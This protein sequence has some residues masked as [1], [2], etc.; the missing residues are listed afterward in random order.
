[1]IGKVYCL[2]LATIVFPSV[3]FIGCNGALGNP[4]MNAS[5]AGGN[6]ISENGGTIG[7]RTGGAGG[8]AVV[9]RSGNG[10]TAG[11]TVGGAGVVVAAAAGSVAGGAVAG[12]G[13]TTV[14][15]KLSPSKRAPG[16]LS[17]AP[18]KGEPIPKAPAGEWKYLEMPDT[19]ARDGSPAGFY[20]KFSDVS[21][22]L[23]IFL[24]GGGACQDSFFCN[25]NP[26]NKDYSLTAESILSGIMGIVGPDA[27]PQDPTIDKYQAG[28]FKN[29]PANPVKDW[30]MV[31][32]PFVT[33]DVFTG[34]RTDATVPTYQSAPL[35]F[36]G[37]TNIIKFLSRIIPTFLDAEVVLFTGSS[38]GGFGAFY[39]AEKIMDGFIDYSTVGTR[40]F[41]VTDSGVLFDDDFLAPCL[42]KRWRDLWNMDSNFSR[43]C[44]DCFNADGG[45]IVKGVTDYLLRKYPENSL[46]GAVDSLD[47]EIMKM[48]FSDEMNDCSYDNNPVIN[49]LLYPAGRYSG[50]LRDFRDNHMG[51][52]RHSTFYYA[53][54]THQNFFA[55][56]LEDRFY[57]NNG[58]SMTIAEWLTKVLQGEVVNLDSGS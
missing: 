13:G 25:N 33:G 11:R 48:F 49:A 15:V 16:F 29:D 52:T 8:L 55:P 24:S 12:S 35:Q 26:P 20:Y 57:S 22:N 40:V 23:M 54:G 27:I 51:T 4:P 42:Q 36:V 5:I 45:G 37:R 46:G 7:P 31:F 2:Y 6:A 38:A 21:K 44:K 1:M 17:E 39:N 47:D 9:G 30:N 58:L 50:G 34:S 28:V 18:P 10:A 53:G 43:D 32:I 56:V 19:Q 14:H 41:V 3:A